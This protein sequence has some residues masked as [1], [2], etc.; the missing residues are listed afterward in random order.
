MATNITLAAVALLL[1]A[2]HIQVDVNTVLVL[3]PF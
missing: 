1:Q 3:A 2:T